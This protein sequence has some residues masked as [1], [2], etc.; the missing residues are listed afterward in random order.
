MNVVPSV[1][2]INNIHH[3][4][5]RRRGNR[6]AFCVSGEACGFYLMCPEHPSEGL[7]KP[8][9]MRLL[10]SSLWWSQGTSLGEISH[11]W[12]ALCQVMDHI[13]SSGR[14]GEKSRAPLI[15]EKKEQPSE[16]VHNLFHFLVET[17]HVV[18]ALETG[19]EAA[20][21]FHLGVRCSVG[22]VSLPTWF[23]PHVAPG[24]W[25]V[26]LAP[27]LWFWSCKLRKNHRRTESWVYLTYW[28]EGHFPSSRSRIAT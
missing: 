1:I 5:F 24:F 14:S 12:G 4:R 21:C 19:G 17:T 13:A 8:S 20:M 27:S 3:H 15:W 18:C 10:T 2:V 7:D 26:A 25:T 11:P 9:L 22:Q 28:P 23:R 6:N 16:Q